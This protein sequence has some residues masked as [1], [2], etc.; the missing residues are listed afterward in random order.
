VAPNPVRV[1]ARVTA[2]GS[3][4]LTIHDVRGRLIRVLATGMERTVTPYEGVW[5][6]RDALGRRVASGVYVLRYAGPKGPVTRRF[7]VAR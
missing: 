2:P 1:G 5:D 4:R 6:G 3:R 7:V